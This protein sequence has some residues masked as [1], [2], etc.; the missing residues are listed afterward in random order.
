MNSLRLLGSNLRILVIKYDASSIKLQTLPHMYF[1][2]ASQ[3]HT[4]NICSENTE[5]NLPQQPGKKYKKP[6]DY[7]PFQWHRRPMFNIFEQSGDKVKEN[8]VDPSLPK[9][10]F[11]LSDELKDADERV[12]QYF[13]CQ[14]ASRSEAREAL[15]RQVLKRIQRHPNDFS[16]LE[17]KI[18]LNTIQI[19]GLFNHK[20]RK[21]KKEVVFSRIVL[22]ILIN[23]RNSMLNHLRKMDYERYCWLLEELDL[24]LN[25]PPL[26]AKNEKYCKKWDLRRLTKEYCKKMVVDKKAAYHEEL[27]K[28][29][30]EFLEEKKRIL[31]WIEEEEKALNVK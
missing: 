27:K 16:S 4:S 8:I 10:D 1:G 22:P 11:E 12:K 25:P 29:Q 15:R 23:R 5:T 14:T 19:R 26:G 20:E 31:A 28:Q 2:V 21:G 18:A 9:P 30:A 6:V 7:L 3:F 24:Y 13:S 17:V